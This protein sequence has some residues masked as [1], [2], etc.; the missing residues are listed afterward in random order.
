MKV[1][2]LFHVKLDMIKLLVLTMQQHKWLKYSYC[3]I[4]SI[5]KNLGRLRILR[6]LITKLMN[7]FVY[8]TNRFSIAL[9]HDKCLLD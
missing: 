1:H 2:N 8:Q 9:L 4:V 3:F 7:E 5:S 6:L